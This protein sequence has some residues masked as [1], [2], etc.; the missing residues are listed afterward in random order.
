MTRAKVLFVQQRLFHYRVPF[1]ERLRELLASEDIELALIHGQV[2]AYQLSRDDE[3]TLE[4]ATRV[5]YRSWRARDIELVWQPCFER[6][7][8]SD[9]V[10]VQQENK[11]LLN[12][13]LLATRRLTKTRVAF[14]GHGVNCQSP[15]PRRLRERWK[16]LLVETPDWWFAYT[17]WTAMRLRQAGVP[18]QRI[19]DVQNATDTEALAAT[20]D[21][22]S[23]EHL[24]ERRRT[25]S[26]GDGPTGVY[27]GSLYDLKMIDFLLD[28]AHRIRRRA[29]GFDL[30]VIGDGPDRDKV[31]RA[32]KDAPWIH[33]TG[34]LFGEELATH[35]ALGD[36]LLN[37]GLVGLSIVDG[38]VFGLP[39]FTTDCGVHSPEIAY[40]EPGRNGEMTPVH[41]ETYA[42]RVC[43]V[44]LEPERLASLRAR[45]AA[46]AA[47][48][49]VD[50]M[51]ARFT[52][53]ILE[54]LNR[55]PIR[56]PL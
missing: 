34:A 17:G 20:R 28:A 7:A 31:D 24:L 40:L 23:A 11:L 21:A 29:P 39:M 15:D 43:Q 36:A 55:P 9:L 41:L 19:T 33:V 51:A 13:L 46:D 3:G 37:P 48:F 27:C 1:Y 45:A 26:L 49:T 18:P 56:G 52:R 53:G 38:F 54:C 42:D 50:E 32:A 8:Q 35:L 30:I 25:L 16:R 22:L 2:P 5:D 4:W 12:Y 6:A 44:L 47:R 14:W 10:I